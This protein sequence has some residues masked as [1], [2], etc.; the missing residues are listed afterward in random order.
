MAE[1]ILK[2]AGGKRQLLPEITARAPVAFDRYHEP[3]LGGGAVFFDL[4]PSDGSVNDL[5]PRLA[6]FYRVV[7]DHPEALVAA[8]RTHEHDEFN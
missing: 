2:W 7:R 1:P 3:F 5:N 4:E 6:R 8:S